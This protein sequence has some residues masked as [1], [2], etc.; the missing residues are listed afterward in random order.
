MRMTLDDSIPCQPGDLL[1]E[2]DGKEAGQVTSVAPQSLAGRR[3]LLAYVKRSSE[4]QVVFVK[5]S[6]PLEVIGKA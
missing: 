4:N 6:D 1:F 5:S 3:A 2:A